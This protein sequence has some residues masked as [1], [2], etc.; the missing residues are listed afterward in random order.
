MVKGLVVFL[1]ST[2]PTWISFQ[3]AKKGL[4]V[5]LLHLKFI[6]SSEVVTRNLSFLF[7]RNVAP[8]GADLWD[9]AALA[10]TGREEDS[11]ASL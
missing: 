2:E 7:I 4:V 6:S 8:A 9:P 1:W 11:A 5:L 10:D 3:E